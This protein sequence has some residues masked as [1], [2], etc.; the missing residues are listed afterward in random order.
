MVKIVYAFSSCALGCDGSCC[1]ASGISP[2]VSAN[3][4]YAPE[5]KT[6]VDTAKDARRDANGLAP[7]AQRKPS[8]MR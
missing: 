1:H 4:G 5:T 2:G 8:M 7:R 3:A 6:N